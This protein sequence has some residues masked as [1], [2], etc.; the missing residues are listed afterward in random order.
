MTDENGVFDAVHMAAKLPRFRTQHG[1]V[2]ERSEGYYIRYYD[3]G[4]AKKRASTEPDTRAETAQRRKV[5]EFLCPLGVEKM[6]LRRLQREHMKKV[7]ARQR[8]V[9]QPDPKEITVHQ[10]WLTERLPAIEANRA[11]KTAKSYKYN[12]QCYCQEYFSKKI[13]TR[14]TTVEANQFLTELTERKLANG[15]R[16]LSR[17]SVNFVRTIVSGVFRHAQN[18]G[19]IDRNP[20]S[21]VDL[22]VKYKPKEPTVIYTMDEA[23]AI[24]RAIP[25][26]KTDVRLFAALCLFRGLMPSEAAALRWDDIDGEFISI[27]RA[28]P[29]G[30]VGETKTTNRVAAVRILKPVAR[31]IEAWREKCGKAEGFIF[32]RRNS[33]SCINGNQFETMKIMPYGRKAIGKRWKGLY[34][35][36]R[37]TSDAL[38]HLTGDTR[39]SIATLRNTKTTVDGHYVGPDFEAEQRG[40]I[41]LEQDIERKLLKA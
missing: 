8:G 20:I 17:S 33:E 7:N 29:D 1:Q 28:A 2:V 9:H 38:Y 12:W 32:K 3:W 30:H 16:G 6:E 37:G 15:D 11:W 14:Y 41:L 10:F 36:R 13:L 40:S 24:I 5:S 31:L 25:E 19:L 18:K 22:L 26:E 39:A 23:V 4:V 35:G 27:R 34:G 21:D